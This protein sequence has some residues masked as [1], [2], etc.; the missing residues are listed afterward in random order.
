VHAPGLFAALAL[1]SERRMGTFNA[2]NLTIT[3]WAFATARIRAEGLFVA[4]AL[5][6]EQRIGTFNAQELAS[7]AWAFATAG[8]R[9]PQLLAALAKHCEQRMG[10]FN[11]QNLANT[12]WAFATA[13]I[14]APGL[15]ATLAKHSEQRMGTLN[16]QNLASTAW[17]FATAGVRAPMLFAALAVHSEQRMST[18]NAQELANTAWAFATAGV[19]A[20]ELFAALAVQFEQR[21]GS[22]NA[23]NLPNTAWAF[24][25]AGVRAPELFAA[26]AL[27]SE[28]RMGTFN[29]QGFANTAW[30]FGTAG[31]HAPELFAALALHSEQRIGTFNAQGLANTAWVLAAMYLLDAPTK[32]TS[33]TATDGTPALHPW[34]RLVM[35]MSERYLKNAQ[36]GHAEQL[37]EQVSA[38]ELALLVCHTAQGCTPDPLLG[39]LRADMRARSLALNKGKAA[40]TPSATQLEVSA[41]LCAAGWEHA[42]EACLEGGLLVVDM[43]CTATH[44]VVEFNRPSHFLSHVQSGEESYDGN[45]SLKTKLLEALGWRVH[46]VGWRAWERDRDAEMAQVA[47]APL[48]AAGQRGIDTEEPQSA[49]IKPAPSRRRRR[50]PHAVRRPVHGAGAD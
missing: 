19:R 22:S 10:T 38:L 18:F 40:V 14:C 42:D 15:F 29:A 31:L 47:A 34:L 11:T 39:R 26:L 36:A 1:H 27:H 17:A 37:F 45:S 6:F 46:R 12:A 20:P 28:R 7:S 3:A 16:A 2:Q 49:E 9:A 43:A 5:H 48:P 4:L 50:R 30:A 13:G 35:S 24:A 44:V 25:T 8:M 33:S 32:P 41:R 23:Q 21:M